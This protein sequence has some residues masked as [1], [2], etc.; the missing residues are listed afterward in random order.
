MLKWY[1]GYIG[2]KYIKIKLACFFLLFKNVAPRKFKITYVLAYIS[3]G[4]LSGL[5]ERY[6]EICASN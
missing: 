3:V 6:L 5:E 1:F 2:L 4:Q